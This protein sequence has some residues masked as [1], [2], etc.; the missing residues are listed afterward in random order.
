MGY[1]QVERS[2]ASLPRPSRNRSRSD[3]R[4][5]GRTAPDY[6]SSVVSFRTR[7]K[8]LSLPLLN[9]DSAA[10]L[11]SVL[12]AL[13]PSGLPD[14]EARSK[15]VAKR[16]RRGTPVVIGCL[17][18]YVRETCD[19]IQRSIHVKTNCDR[20]F[21]FTGKKV[22]PIRTGCAR[23]RFCRT[24]GAAVLSRPMSQKLGTS[25]FRRIAAN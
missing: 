14:S 17:V 1:Y 20:Q 13:G 23:C 15:G 7:V 2:P 25:I 21:F 3:I 9:E 8:R 19:G 4:A 22:S 6:S 5:A 24:A 16:K 11:R 18:F 12:G 10:A